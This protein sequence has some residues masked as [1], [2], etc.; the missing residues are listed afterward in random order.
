MNILHDIAAQAV[1]FEVDTWRKPDTVY[2]GE[3]QYI[4]CRKLTR[5]RMEFPAKAGVQ[6]IAGL[7]MFRVFADSHLAVTRTGAATSA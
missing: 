6:L 7:R 5:T 2:V 4:A 3:Q 1:K